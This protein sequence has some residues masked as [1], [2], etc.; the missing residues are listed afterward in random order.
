MIAGRSPLTGGWNAIG[1][2]P[3]GPASPTALLGANSLNW[4]IAERSSRRGSA[5]VHGFSPKSS[6]MSKTTS[7]HSV[8]SSGRL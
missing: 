2:M 7:R 1:P 4:L 6:L 5:H 3:T 8:P